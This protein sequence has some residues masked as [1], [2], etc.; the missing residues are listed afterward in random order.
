M[1]RSLE[2]VS[3]QL[4]TLPQ[5]AANYMHYSY[6][7]YCLL[8]LRIVWQHITWAWFSVA[9]HH[10][11]LADKSNEKE[12]RN[13]LC[14]SSDSCPSNARSQ[15]N[16]FS[17]TYLDQFRKLTGYS[18]SL[19]NSAATSTCNVFFFSYFIPS[20]F[21]QDFPF[22]PESVSLVPPFSALPPLLTHSLHSFSSFCLPRAH[23]LQH[24][25]SSV[26]RDNK[27]AAEQTSV[28]MCSSCGVTLLYIFSIFLSLLIPF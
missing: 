25:M 12:G 22:S 1:R 17:T 2:W 27:W 14:A 26:C 20:L 7:T 15:W 8:I 9:L 11:T 23:F 18:V 3:V 16:L 4:W 24:L 10:L 6:F 19:H 21:L 28:A 13:V 5:T